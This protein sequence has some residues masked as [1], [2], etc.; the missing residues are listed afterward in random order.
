MYPKFIEVRDAELE[1]MLSLNVA[2]ICGFNEYRKDADKTVIEMLDSSY[3]IVDHTYEELKQMITES[4][5]LIRKQ[6]PRL[7][8]E[9]SLTME[10]IKGMVGEPVW[11]SNTGEWGLITKDAERDGEITEGFLIRYHDGTMAY[12]YEEGLKKFPIYRMRK[13]RGQFPAVTVYG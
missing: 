1:R 12:L 5:C 13:K 10:D 4:G 8:T 3:H 11:N 7:D 6:D 9:H 2:N